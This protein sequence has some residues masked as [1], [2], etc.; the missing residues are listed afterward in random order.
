MKTVNRKLITWGMPGYF[1]IHGIEIY[2]IS[3]LTYN[4]DESH[5]YHVCHFTFTHTI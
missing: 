3:K 2:G 5:T 4:Y 1:K